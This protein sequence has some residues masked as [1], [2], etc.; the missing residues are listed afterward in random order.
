MVAWVE[1]LDAQRVRLLIKTQAG[2]RSGRLPVADRRLPRAPTGWSVS[3]S[4][5]S[6][7]ASTDIPTLRRMLLPDDWEGHPLLKS[8]AVDT[9]YP[10]YRYFE[11]PRRHVVTVT[12]ETR[13]SADQLPRLQRA[14]PELDYTGSERADHEHGAAAPVGPRR[15]PRD[16][17]ARRRDGRRRRRGHRLPAPVPREAGRDA[18][19]RAVPVDRLEDRL[20]G[21]DD[22]RARL[23]DGGRAARPDRGAQARAVPARAGGRTAAGRLALLVARHLVHG[24][25]RRARAAAPR[26]SSTASASA[27]WCSTCS[28]RSWARGC[29][30]DSTR[31]AASRYDL[32]GRLERPV[33]DDPG[34]DRA[35]ARRIRGDAR[36][37]RVL[38]DADAGRR[39]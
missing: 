11:L 23:R 15:V 28:S 6:A 27:S 20:R 8:Y 33:P 35:A 32:P 18:G 36:G 25:G 16:P 17:D 37:Q 22:E 39:A 4:T 29:C 21:R 3:A 19:L 13:T 5:C 30:T 26:S 38:H 34:P 24:H 7:S 9:P 2:R 14:S 1:N 12:T 31:W 10:P